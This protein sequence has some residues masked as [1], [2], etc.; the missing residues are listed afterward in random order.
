MD[1]DWERQLED[2][3]WWDL[4]RERGARSFPPGALV[5]RKRL[6][7]GRMS[8][9]NAELNRMVGEHVAEPTEPDPRPWVF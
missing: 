4:C 7:L 9:V 6:M 3:A 2:R 5:A 8:A 1:D